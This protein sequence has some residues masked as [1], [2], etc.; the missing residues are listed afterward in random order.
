MSCQW[1]YHEDYY[2]CDCIGTDCQWQAACYNFQCDYSCPQWSPWSICASSQQIRSR[3]C[4]CDSFNFNQIGRVCQEYRY[5]SDYDTSDNN[6]TPTYGYTN[7]YPV[8]TGVSV[9]FLICII[10]FTI[11]MIRRLKRKQREL[12]EPIVTSN[13]NPITTNTYPTDNNNIPPTAPQQVPAYDATAPP[14][15]TADVQQPPEYSEKNPRIYPSLQQYGFS[16][17]QRP[18]EG[19]NGVSEYN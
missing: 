15:Y 12:Q 5:C 17:T 4:K 3:I 16:D 13:P 6:Y 9:A 19:A 1:I 10:I 18:A 8:V 7:F 14:L 2:S 11:C